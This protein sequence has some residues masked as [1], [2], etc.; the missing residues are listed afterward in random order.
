MVLF[1]S[2]KIVH[3]RRSDSNKYALHA[4]YT[5]V[6]RWLSICC[7][8]TLLKSALISSSKTGR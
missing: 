4:F 1:E 6:G 3:A 5:F 2:E 7:R 8:I